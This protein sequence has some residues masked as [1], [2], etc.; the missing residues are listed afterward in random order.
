[1]LFTGPSG[2][3]K[4]TIARFS[5]RAQ[6]HRVLSDDRIVIRADGPGFRVWGTPWHG[7][8]PL[9]SDASAPLAAIH[10]IHQ[11]PGLR[12]EPLGGAAAAATVLS[13]A[14]VPAHDPVAA[15]RALE[16][17]E[18]IVSRVPVVRLGCPLDPSI[19]PYAWERAA[20]PACAA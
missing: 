11:T 15:E 6:G 17:A 2:A 16:L 19:V 9:S 10:A 1:M 7:D 18:R 12:A 20:I 4:T 13:N 5:L 14:F 3:G 8:A